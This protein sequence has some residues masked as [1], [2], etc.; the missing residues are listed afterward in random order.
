M[1]KVRSKGNVSTERRLR[2]A[3]VRAGMRG[4][5][6]HAKQVTG[7]PDF[8]FGK[9]RLAVFVD[10]CFWHGCPKCGH[11]PKANRKF[12]AAKIRR[13]RE[14]DRRT[15]ARLRAQ[16]YRVLRFREHEL[17]RG[18]DGCVAAINNALR[19]KDCK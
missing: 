17:K 10:G 14:R 11:I 6:L 5:V 3:L 1:A 18:L 12:W 8:Y 2:S 16:G 19:R 9:E 7:F 13:N 4:W 15:S